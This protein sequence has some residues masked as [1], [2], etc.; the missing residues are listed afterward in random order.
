MQWQPT[1]G[2]ASESKVVDL[3]IQPPREGCPVNC[4]IEGRQRL[5]GIIG[6]L[7]GGLLFSQVAALRADQETGTGT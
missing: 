3:D 1:E 4:I 7:H 6:A 2:L 5:A